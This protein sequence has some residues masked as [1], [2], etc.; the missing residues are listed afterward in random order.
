M[1]DPS[2]EVQ[3]A[4]SA[5]S[6][7][8]GVVAVIR[9]GNEFLMIR[10]AEGLAA[11]GAWC[12]PGGAVEPGE[13]SAEAI[14]RELGEEVGLEGRAVEQV[15][16]WTRPDGRLVL[17]WWQVETTSDRVIPDPAEV[18]EARWMTEAQIR[19]TPGVL[20]GLL[21]FMDHLRSTV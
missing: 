7:V 10:R 15:W 17:D 5:S 1:A 21:Q 18:A 8:H 11:G 9:R 3:Q 2:E 14:V 20:P 19:A 12:F 16:R 6:P 4:E 13:T